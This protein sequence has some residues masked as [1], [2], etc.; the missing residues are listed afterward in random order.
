MIPNMVSRGRLNEDA[1][2][3]RG[4]D[5]GGDGLFDH[6]KGASSNIL[7]PLDVAMA[8][9]KHALLAAGYDED[10]ATV[11]ETCMGTICDGRYSPERVVAFTFGERK[12]YGVR[13]GSSYE[14]YTWGT[15]YKTQIE[16]INGV[17]QNLEDAR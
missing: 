2:K 12:V 14:P 9:W 17:V 4:F 1:R 3:A 6:S 10:E 15:I 11:I 5:Q 7:S 8:R 13:S 16:A